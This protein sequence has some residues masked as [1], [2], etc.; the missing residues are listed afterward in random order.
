MTTVVREALEGARREHPELARTID[1]ELATAGGDDVEVQIPDG[2]AAAAA[3]RIATDRPAIDPRALELDWREVTLR[4]GEVCGVV[5]A[6]DERLAPGA[7]ALAA[8]ARGGV[9]ELVVRWLSPAERT[10]EGVDEIVATLVLTRALKPWLRALAGIALATPAGRAY[11]GPSCPA[12]GGPPDFAA[13]EG[14]GGERRLL[15]S[16][17]DAELSFARTGCPF[18]AEESPKKLAYFAYGRYRLYVCDGCGGYLKTVDRRE[19]WGETPLPV[20][21][22]LAVG[23]DVA[24]TRAGYGPGSKN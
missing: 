22:V 15:C 12:C 23:L 18:C 1:F 13:L 11:A 5:A 9:R 17:C 19:T 8:A 24:A 16:R 20:E 10:A 3:E 14:E 21:R 4:I 2:F 7:K 6:T